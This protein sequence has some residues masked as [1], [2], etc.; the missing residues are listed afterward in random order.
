MKIFVTGGA[1]Y[2]GTTLVPR[3]L[4]AG[5][6]VCVFDCL[7]HGIEP[8]L[9]CFRNR[10][11]AMV[12]GD[13]RD[14]ALLEQSARDCDGFIHLAAISGYPACARSPEEATGVNVEG[15]R[16]VAVVAGRRRPVVFA[17]TSS[18]YGSATTSLCTEDEPLRPVSLYGESKAEAESI[19]LGE[20]GAVVYRLATV[21]GVSPRMRLDL[22]VN[23]F[24][25]RALHEGR[26]DVYE[27]HARRSFVHVADV[28]RAFLM[29]IE[30][31]AAMKGRVFNVGDESQNVTKWELCQLIARAIP[32]V[33][34]VSSETGKD[35]DR[36]DY[37]VSCARIKAL[38][39]QTS[40][41]LEEGILELTRA[42]HWMRRPTLPQ[43]HS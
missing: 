2:L 6:E 10:N 8:L 7:K 27:R 5:H 1:G 13:I 16:N 25:N 31:S 38:G 17:S 11:F 36:R 4:E 28:G 22:L 40:V 39:F 29:A 18:C 21:Y 23:D 24:V 20:C 15:S 19:L 33:K 14:R 41:S 32:T 3:L 37:A 30:E 43:G 12:R 26:L 42:L 9:P 35:L 34:L